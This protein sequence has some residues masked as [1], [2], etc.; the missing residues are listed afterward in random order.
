VSTLLVERYEFR[1]KTLF[2]GI[3]GFKVSNTPFDRYLNRQP[4]EKEWI[5]HTN[6]SKTRKSMVIPSE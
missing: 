5:C 2:H 6:N 1:K 4:D 3:D